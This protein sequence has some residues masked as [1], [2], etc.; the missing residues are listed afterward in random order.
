MLVYWLVYRG[1]GKGQLA[2]LNPVFASYSGIVALISILFF[3]EKL[4]GPVAIGLIAVFGGILLMNT[5][6][7]GL[8]SKRLNIVPGL[9]EVGAAA[10]LAAIW[11]I[12]WDRFVHNRDFLAYALLMYF[13]MTVAAIVAAKAQKAK[14]RPINPALWK[15]LFLIGLGETVAYL[16]ISFGFSKTTY[17]SIVALISGSFSVPTV[18]LAH[19]FLK[20]RITRLQEISVGIILAGIIV[21][22]LR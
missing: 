13:F 9:K 21:I 15:F 17:V 19:L 3:A 16:S 1:F 6:L 10:I 20:E 18:I 14:L 7:R 5:D 2:V 12:L 11:T 22:S 8:R 4:T